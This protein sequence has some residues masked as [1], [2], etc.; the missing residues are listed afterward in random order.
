M[1]SE[2]NEWANCPI[3]LSP[4]EIQDPFIVIDDFFSADSLTGHLKQLQI[5]R[6]R[7]VGYGYYTDGH[8]SPSGL[9]FNY[10]LTLKLIEVA[11]IL[12]KP[13]FSGLML[14]CTFKDMDDIRKEPEEWPEYPCNL[15]EAEL[16]DPALGIRL[17]FRGYQ[18]ADYRAQLYE[19]LRYGLSAKPAKEFVDAKDLLLIYENLQ[20]LFGIMWL[21]Y[22]RNN[23]NTDLEVSEIVVSPAPELYRLDL[24]FTPSYKE[25]LTKSVA[26]IKKKLPSAWAIIC[27]GEKPGKDNVIYFLVLTAD[28][29]TGEALALGTMLEESCSAEKVFILVHYANAFLNAVNSGDRFFSNALA[30]PSIFLSGDL[31]MP[32]FRSMRNIL[33]VDHG[34]ANWERWSRQANEFLTGAEF[35]LAEEAYSA[36]LFSMHQSAECILVAVIRSV[37]GYRIST[38]NL[39]RLLRI[40]Q[41]FTEDLTIVFDLGSESGKSNFRVLKDSY[42]GVRYRDNYLPDTNVIK[43]LFPAVTSL[44][45]KAVA[46][47][48]RYLMTS[49]L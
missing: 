16:L 39:L 14:K 21:I 19:W 5:W 32:R 23:S 46:I 26:I 41:M 6:D 33:N 43:E 42:V 36:A 38:H 12:K 37:L 2:F 7:V 24:D 20:K 49:I 10:E 25:R 27:L 31:L 48:R 17:F 45:T 35:Y 30:C 4:K 44:V 29:E 47:H 28:F 9:L 18:L 1:L 22:N 40:T 8:G 13:S 15:N 3:T 11:L 34:E